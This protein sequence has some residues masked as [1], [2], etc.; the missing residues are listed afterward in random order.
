MKIAVLDVDGHNFP[1]LALMKISAWHKAQ[2]DEVEWFFGFNEY[3]KVYMSKVFTFTEDFNH[4]INAKEIIKG[5]TGYGLKNKLPTEIESMYPDYSLYRIEDTAY[6]YLT[7][8]CPRGCDFCIVAEKEG[9]YSYK[10]ANLKEFWN[11]QREIKLLDP[12]ILACKDWK[13]LFNQLI[14]SKSYVD[15]T[16]GLDIRLMTR[17]KVEMLNKIKVKMIHFA[18]DNYEFNTYEKLKEFRPLL[19]FNGRKLRVY[20]LTNFNTTIEQ[21]LERIYKLKEL[22]Y[23]PYVMI[24]EKWNAP[25]QIR[26]LQRWV[27]NKFIFR[28]CDKFED[29]QKIS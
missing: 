23:D 3:D 6:G 17:E 24:F 28:S 12:N 18:W 22:D 9:N 5:G 13:D 11:G 16:Q 2:G 20:V 26:R 14:D 29:Y 4:V 15:F 27:N 19:K 10:V 25:R 8:G 21:D 1:N 7:R